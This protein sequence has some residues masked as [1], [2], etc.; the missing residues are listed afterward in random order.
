MKTKTEK[1][2]LVETYNLIRAI[3]RLRSSLGG[4]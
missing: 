2:E 3:A 1:L 4:W